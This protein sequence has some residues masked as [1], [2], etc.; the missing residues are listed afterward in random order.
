MKKS[1]TTPSA[2]DPPEAFQ[3]GETETHVEDAVFGEVSEGGPNYRN[4][5]DSIKDHNA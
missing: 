5:R 4:V 2:N 3:Y 1:K